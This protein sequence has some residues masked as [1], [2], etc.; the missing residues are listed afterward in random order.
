MGL[1]QRERNNQ[2]RI[3][4]VYDFTMGVLWTV[5]GLF[6]LLYRQ[7]GYEP[8]FDHLVAAI[9]GVTCMAYGIFR[10]WRGTKRKKEK[11]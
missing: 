11:W 8:D 10:L 3:R 9:F 6:L 4:A 2:S 7:L 1:E 5:V